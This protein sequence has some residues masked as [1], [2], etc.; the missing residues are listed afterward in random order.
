M[1]LA[2]V[3]CKNYIQVIYMHMRLTVNGD[4]NWRLVP[5]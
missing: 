2:Q 4:L 1:R 5:N 3:A